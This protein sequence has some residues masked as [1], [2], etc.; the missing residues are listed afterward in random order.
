MKLELVNGLDILVKGQFI[1]D[2]ET[3]ELVLR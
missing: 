1:I 2:L 3:L